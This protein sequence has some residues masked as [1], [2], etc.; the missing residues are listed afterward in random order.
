[1][2]NFFKKFKKHFCDHDWKELGHYYIDDF[3]VSDY[4]RDYVYAKVYIYYVKRCD[5]CGK[6][7]GN[8]VASQKFC[9]FRN[10]TMALDKFKCDLE[11]K[12]IIS[13]AEFF[14]KHGLIQVGKK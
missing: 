5:K 8:L 2:F 10:N 11:G 13:E 6:Y 4:S 3:I 1:M 9:L 14:L 12:G 7:E